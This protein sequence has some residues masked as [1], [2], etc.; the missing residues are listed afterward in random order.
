MGEGLDRE[1]L[2]ARLADREQRREGLATH[3]VVVVAQHRHERGDRARVADQA[4]GLAD[5]RSELGGGLF[6]CLDELADGLGV[7]HRPEGL[8]GLDLLLGRAAAQQLE[9]GVEG[10]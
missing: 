2:G 10:H 6:E 4:Q 5:G 8:G 9:P 1:L 3:V 7:G